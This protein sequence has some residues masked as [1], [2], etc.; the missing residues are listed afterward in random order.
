MKLMKYTL[1][2]LALLM[3]ALSVPAFA[4]DNSAATAP[5]V[6]PKIEDMDYQ[7]FLAYQKMV[8]A[9]HAA[10]ATLS[11]ENLTPEKVNKYAEMG[12][13]LGVAINEGLGAVTKNVEQFAQTSAGKWLMVLITWKV[14]GNDAVALVKSTVRF[15]TGIGL[16]TIGVPFFVYIYR[17][18]CVS[19]PAIVEQTKIG[20][21]TIKRKY[22]GMTRPIHD[23]SGPW[24]YAVCFGVFVLICVLIM[25]A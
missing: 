2:V 16:L 17:R 1:S 12:K 4:Q 25:F 24:G 10:N 13:G 8:K 22:Q 18:N 14:M 9:Q 5:A 11:L 21:L 7:Q 6:A 23:D 19:V 20:F 15:A 3:L